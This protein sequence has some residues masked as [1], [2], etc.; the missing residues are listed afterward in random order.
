MRRLG[1]VLLLA[2][3]R[4]RL[5]LVVGATAATTALLLA[6]A[7]VVEL[8]RTHLGT[9][10]GGAIG[11]VADP[12]TRPGV[13]LALLL[14]TVPLLLLLDQAVRL[15]STSRLRRT[16]AL[17]VAGATGGDLRRW[18]SLEVGAPAAVGAL[19][20]LPCWLVLHAALRAGRGDRGALLPEG[21]GPGWWTL[22]VLAAVAAYGALVGARR[23]AGAGRSEPRRRRPWWLVPLALLVALWSWDDLF[24]SDL[25]VFAVV[26]LL[27][28]LLGLLA[29]TAAGLVARLLVRRAGS[30]PALLAGRRLAADPGPAGRAAAA[31]GAVGLT[32]GV[33]PVF[34]VDLRDTYVGSDRDYYEVPALVAGGCALL[35]LAVIAASL[36]VH[37][38]ETVLERR[39]EMATL[40]ATGV[41]P[42]VV[43]DSQRVECLAVTVPLAVLGAVVGS[44]G[45]AWL[46]VSLD[47]SPGP[48]AV[49]VVATAAVSALASWLA[50]TA[51]RPWVRD[52]VD[53]EH[54]RTA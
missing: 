18:G 51:L 8:P 47:R 42:R 49:A 11:V 2:G 27:V 22:L 54:L 28:A 29:P 15:G 30:V 17:R 24:D 25:G 41:P 34:L 6:A 48:V 5:A 16:E 7:S 1:L 45:Y 43:S 40:V 10:R 38:T 26:V 53:P 32:L 37:S 4:G 20:G 21:A 13:V 50:T 52:A 35:A 14:M 12:G 39:R 31:V 36:A 3:G 46:T 9:G 33:V 23:P 19:L 44:T